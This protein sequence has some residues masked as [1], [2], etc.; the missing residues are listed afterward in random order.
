MDILGTP[1]TPNHIPQT[2]IPNPHHYPL[3]LII[4]ISPSSSHLHSLTL[5][6]TI[7]PSSSHPC[8][9]TLAI[10]II[11]P[12]SSHP[13]HHNHLTHVFSFPIILISLSSS[14]S[15]LHHHLTLLLI[16]PSSSHP[17]HHL[18]HHHP[19][20]TFI[21]TLLISPSSFSYLH[22]LTFNIIISPSLSHLIIISP[23]SSS[24]HPH[25]HLNQTCDSWCP[26]KI[27]SCCM[28]SLFALSIIWHVG[29]IKAGGSC[30]RLLHPAATQLSEAV[31]KE[32]MSIHASYCV[33]RVTHCSLNVW[34]RTATEHIL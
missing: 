21:L 8:Y 13:H 20:I 31:C 29:E 15:Y 33:V 2:P 4:T 19:F 27:K 32:H 6:I 11:S 16:L 26:R 3:I 1:Q 28:Y 24:F 14:S 34:K 10:I 12:S 18:T 22:H 30:P 7:F 23:S 9:L 17:H 5:I 25:H